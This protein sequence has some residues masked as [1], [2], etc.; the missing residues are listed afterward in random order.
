MDARIPKIAGIFEEAFSNIEEAKVSRDKIRAFGKFQKRVKNTVHKINQVVDLQLTIKKEKLREN[1]MR[2]LGRYSKKLSPQKE[3]VDQLHGEYL[4]QS[5]EARNMWVDVWT[6]MNEEHE[7][8][9]LLSDL[10]YFKI[11]AI[12]NSCIC[13]V[14]QE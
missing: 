12:L 11:L 7:D 14:K 3:K 2:D 1:M 6:M 5:M 4:K 8:T 10:Q 9:A 13:E